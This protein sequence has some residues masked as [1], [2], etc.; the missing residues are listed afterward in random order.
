MRDARPYFF[1]VVLTLAMLFPLAT[2][3][4]SFVTTGKFG[5]SYVDAFDIHPVFVSILMI[6]FSILTSIIA[7]KNYRPVFAWAFCIAAFVYS[8][9]M[10]VELTLTIGQPVPILGWS[11]LALAIAFIITIIASTRPRK[12]T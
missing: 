3:L 8:V 5:V 6:F 11:S 4:N 2:C 1:N 12:Q 7:I 9:P 10:A